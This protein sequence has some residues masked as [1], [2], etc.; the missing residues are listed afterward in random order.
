MYAVVSL[1]NEGDRRVRP[2]GRGCLEETIE[3]KGGWIT[4]HQPEFTAIFIGLSSSSNELFWVHLPTDTL[5]WRATAYYYHYKRHNLR[6]EM[7]DQLATS[8]VWNQVEPFWRAI[9]W[10]LSLLP[11]PREEFGEISTPFLTNKP[12]VEVDSANNAQR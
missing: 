4:N 7:F 2:A 8:R 10:C 11:E 9:R 1:Q 5:R 12:P 3:T 6:E